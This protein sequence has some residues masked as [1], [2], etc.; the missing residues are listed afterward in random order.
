MI[1]QKYY[2][3]ELTIKLTQQDIDFIIEQLKQA[4]FCIYDFLNYEKIIK[5]LNNNN[6]KN[7]GIPGSL[8]K[9][10]VVR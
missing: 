8:P 4:P 2:K 5:K 1:T 3:E 7:T 9:K 10:E 6:T